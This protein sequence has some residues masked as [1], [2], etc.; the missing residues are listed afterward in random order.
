MNR[1]SIRT[2][3]T[4]AFSLAFGLLILL[5]C[6]GMIAYARHAAENSADHLLE[7]AAQKLERELSSMGPRRELSEIQEEEGDLASLSLSLLLVDAQGH[8]IEK[9]PGRAPAWPRR[10]GDGWRV[11]MFP[12]GSETVIIA[13]NW[14]GTE[15]ALQ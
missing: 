8:V 11:R 13:L 7:A 1:N 10:A 2:R 9:S 4:L 5:A 6:G 15:M 12:H 14:A 3:M